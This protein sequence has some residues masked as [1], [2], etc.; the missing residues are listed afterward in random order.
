MNNEIKDCPP[1]GMALWLLGDG[2]MAESVEWIVENDFEGVSL[3]QN[4]MDADKYERTDTAAAIA[5]SGLNVTYHGNVNDHLINFNTLDKDFIDRMIDDVIWWHENTGGVLSCCTDSVN[6]PGENHKNIFDCEI[7]RQLMEKLI[8]GLD[9]YGIR[10]G[11]ENSFGGK[12]KFCG[13][14][15]I[16]GFENTKTGMLLDAGH[17]NIH[18]R[19]DGIEGE[20]EIGDY[21]KRIP[22]E[23]Y[24]VHFSDN[25]GE[26][27][28]HKQLGYG[29]LD[30]ASMFAAL[31]ATGFSGIFTVEVCV[32]ILSGKYKADI[33]NPAQTDPI[34]ISRDK[35]KERWKQHAEL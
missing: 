35:I 19:S 30:L 7:N 21:I 3:L 14:N 31:R 34:L 8:S 22:L 16:A 29:N 9:R 28:E 15:D 20:T 6:V 11:I 4:V 26:K 27:D 24:E 23:I 13:L 10:I 2:S 25:F 5:S 12:T 17:A 32:D 1:V 18:V 33:H